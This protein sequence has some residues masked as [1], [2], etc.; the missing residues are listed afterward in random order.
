VINSRTKV[1]GVVYAAL[2]AL[3]FISCQQT[4][5]YDWQWV[6]LGDG[7]SRISFPAKPI[8]EETPTKSITGGS[9]TSHA[10]KVKPVATVAY[11]CTWFDDPSLTGMSAEDRL[12]QA[13]DN[14]IRG[15]QGTLVSE[16]RLTIQGHPARDVQI[17]ARGNAAF[18][19]R[20]ILAGS[21]LYILMV[22]DVTGRHDAQNIERF[23]NSFTPR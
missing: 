10:L 12:N 8:L 13:R 14:G 22:A 18:D 1:F 21:R 11:G 5:S 7:Q 23:F 15:V 19:N 3:F 17:T 6:D 20:I 16:K 2:S 4:H 9:F